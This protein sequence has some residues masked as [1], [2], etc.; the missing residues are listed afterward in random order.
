[1]SAAATPLAR[2]KTRLAKPR[3]SAGVPVTAEV[4][5]LISAADLARDASDWR[6]AAEGYREALAHDPGLAHI[7]VQLGHA[8]KEL[9]RF[10]EAVG[11]YRRGLELRPE[12]A[13][14]HLHLAHAM[15]RAGQPIEAAD[16]FL[17]A[18]AAGPEPARVHDEL[19]GLAAR[20][21]VVE[22]PP[23]LR[24]SLPEA[25]APLEP[26]ARSAIEA[27]IRALETGEAGSDAAQA[28]RRLIAGSQDLSPDGLQL[29]LDVS[30]L[31]HYFRGG[32][33]PT[34]IQRV[35]LEIVCSALA[36]T[37]P[38]PRLAYFA[39]GGA[40]WTEAPAELVLAACRC[41]V[42]AGG[43]ED[44]DWRDCVERLDAALTQA[45][46][47]Q[48]PQ[49]C[50]LVNLGTSW[51]PNYLLAVRHAK[52]RSGVRYV[53][54]IHDLIPFVR[55][56]TCQ[57]PLVAAATRWTAGAFAHADFFLANSEATRSDL[58]R[59]ARDFGHELEAG[60][61]AVTRLDA[62]LRKPDAERL[63]ARALGLWGLSR[64][65]FVLFVST[66]EPRKNHLAA[67]AAWSELIRR[68]GRRAVP[69]LVCVGGRGWM[70][71]APLAA[72]AQDPELRRK[73]V[74]LSG[75]SDAELALL[76]ES[77]AFTLYPSLYEGW[78]LP[79]TE[80][81]S[82]GKAAV[83]AEAASLP[84]AGG[85]LADY[86][87]P[88]STASLVAAL[89]RMLFE[90]GYRSSRERRIRAEF[91]PRAWR[92]VADQIA[93]QLDAW[94]L[95]DPG[96]PRDPPPRLELGRC[97]TL[98]AVAD[99]RA[100]AAGEALRAGASWWAPEAW[101]CWTNGQPGELAFRNPAPGAALR[102]YVGLHGLPDRDT[103]FR[104][105]GA[106]A[107]PVEGQLDAGRT[108]W[109]ALAT[110]AVEDPDAELRLRVSGERYADLQAAGGSDHRI[111]GIGVCGLMVCAEDDLR[112]RLDFIEAV[113]LDQLEGLV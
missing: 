103:R 104:V 78:G 13:E 7:W 14:T 113:A 99:A 17:R 62:D 87:D 110:S 88:T 19:D 95:A 61:V 68:H 47:L 32:R 108:R 67:F 38:R 69:K 97:Y 109:V 22:V 4:R 82:F 54:F 90:P 27:A 37:T 45:P 102:A 111:L 9:G 42:A 46:R 50:F 94:R 25:G 64:E 49:G 44:P 53:P 31:I 77:C 33:S 72:L 11:A 43:A 30:D 16:H 80:A 70:N 66:L 107:Q 59:V 3:K 29:V 105:E 20:G 2:V 48:F 10:D 63:D 36:D 73:V 85:T 106:G 96:A 86:F 41:S 35:Q 51:F 112:R 56:D 71:E 93:G 26:A 57:P 34:G 23:A 79:V 58:L 28:L 15:K 81:L 74:L 84:E 8:L 60:R 55:P 52:R 6:A 92:D 89:E 76:Y 98:G 83:V 75:V 65:G 40:H 1:M 101:G 5:R 12:L 18:L 21:V 39:G 91:R 24:R 100:A